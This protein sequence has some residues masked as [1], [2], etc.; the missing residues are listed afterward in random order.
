MNL[1][2][3]RGITNIPDLETRYRELAM[4]FHPDKGGST[5]EF[6]SMNDEYK[7]LK[8]ALELLPAIEVKQKDLSIP[9]KRISK[10]RKNAISDSFGDF[11]KEVGKTLIEIGINKINR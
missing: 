8:I 5:Q 6:Q 3:F 1:N 9:A 7:R 11:V 2:F 10:K 4:K